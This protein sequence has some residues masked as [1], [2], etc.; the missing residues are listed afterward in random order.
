MKRVAASAVRY[1]KLG[2]SGAWLD[3]C[4][5]EGVIELS[6]RAITHDLAAT[7][8]WPT[9]EA[10][11][12]AAGRSPSKAKDFLRELR[13]FY[14]LGADCLWITQGNGRLWWAFA[15]PEVTAVDSSDG[16]GLRMRR[17]IGA[18]SG[19]SIQGEPLA[20]HALSTRLTKVAAYQQSICNVDAADYL[21]RRINDEPEPAVARAEHA[22]AELVSCA[23]ALIENLHWRDFEVMV[24]LIFASSGWRRASAVGGSDQADTDMILEQAATGERAFVQVK[25]R[26]SGAT[27]ENYI[28]RFR[29]SGDRFQRMFFVCHSPTGAMAL[30]KD[31][32]IHIW[33]GERLA[34]QAIAAGLF[35]WLV[36]KAR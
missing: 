20:L 18:W 7:G 4:L 16:R 26:A 24:D 6:H 11:Y 23:R 33:L 15:E 21:L 12:R 9:V 5:S 35:D 2:P 14:T 1:I 25:S 29:K 28:G 19:G 34:Q 17:V 30:A 3:R 36:E 32:Q 31:P 27:L 8:D 13:D 22:R 10:A